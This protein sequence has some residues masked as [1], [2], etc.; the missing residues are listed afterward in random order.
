MIMARLAAL[1][2]TLVS[3]LSTSYAA[4]VYRNE[5]A[6]FQLST[7][8]GW[9]VVDPALNLK[10]VKSQKLND[11]QQRAELRKYSSRLLLILS[12]YPP[13]FRGLNPTLKI[14]LKPSEG[15]TP[16]A[17]MESLIP[18]FQKGFKQFKIVQVPSEATLGGVTGAYFQGTY[19]LVVRRSSYP[20]AS[21]MWILPHQG[22]FL[23]IGANTSQAEKDGARQEML[24]AVSSLALF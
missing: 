11:E 10:T 13:S 17:M 18:V 9:H 2:L 23:V 24:D 15:K 12:K 16:M 7:P 1:V 21:E 19:Q 14:D 8:P 22:G 4:D 6:G 5:L 3:A 20:A